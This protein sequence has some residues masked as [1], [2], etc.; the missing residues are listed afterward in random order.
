M[1]LRL[2]VLPFVAACLVAALVLQHS[3]NTAYAQSRDGRAAAATSKLPN[4]TTP[5]DTLFD[6][7]NG[8]WRVEASPR[9]SKLAALVHGV[10]RFTGHWRGNR[11]ENGVSDELRLAKSDGATHLV[12]R[13]QR[14]FDSS[15]RVWNVREIDRSGA[16][17]AAMRPMV[18]KGE[19]IIPAANRVARSRFVERTPN[20]FRY[21]REVSNDGGR[22]W[23]EPVLVVTAERIPARGTPTVPR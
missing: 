21:L 3:C 10:P 7:L 14:V 15:A 2:R 4:A 11:N 1:L 8:E 16:A 19:I 13:F 5:S 22:T 20:H 18:A 17:S 12:L 9:I 6:F 23:E